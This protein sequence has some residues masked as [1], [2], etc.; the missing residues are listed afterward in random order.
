MKN[1]KVFISYS[2]KDEAWKDR[3]ETHLRVLEMQELLNIWVDERIEGGDVWRDEIDESMNTSSVAILLVSANFLTSSFILKTEVPRLLLQ[4]K[5]RG[6][7]I[8]PVIIKPCAWSRVDWLARLQVRPRGGRPLSEGNE[9]Q[10]DV[11]LST[12]SLE[13][14]DIISSI[15]AETS[16]RPNGPSGNIS[17]VGPIAAEAGEPTV[18]KAVVSQSAPRPITER[19]QI[20]AL[21]YALTWEAPVSEQDDLDSLHAVLPASHSVCQSVISGY[22]AYTTVDELDTARIYF[23]YPRANGDDCEQAVRCALGLIKAIQKLNEGH[24]TEHGVKL[25]IRIGIHTG[26]AI[27]Q[28]RP[29]GTPERAI[30]II[31]SISRVAEQL[32]IVAQSDSIFITD[33]TFKMIKG[34]FEVEELGTQSIGRSDSA[35]H[36]YKVLRESTARSRLDVAAMVGLT[37][38]IA[39][40]QEVA[41]LLERWNQVVEGVGQ[42]VLISGEAG[43]GK[44]RIVRVLKE[45]VAKNPQAWLTECFCSPYQSNTPLFPI[46]DL[47]DR[48][49]FNSERLR[50]A[51]SYKKLV[52]FLTQ[53]GMSSPEMITI[54]S[55]LLAVPTEE[56]LSVS[57]LSP[58]QERKQILEALIAILLEVAAGQPVVLVVEDLQWADPTTLELLGMLVDQGTTAPILSVFT[59]RPNFEAPWGIRSHINHIRLTGLSPTNIKEMVSRIAGKKVLP[60]NIISHVV[61]SSDGIPLFVEEL[62]KTVIEADFL[63]DAG[64]HYELRQPVDS[65]IIPSTLRESLTA[66]L[67]RLGEEKLVAQIA[68]TIGREFTFQL[69]LKVVASKD[70][71]ALEKD[72]STLVRGD[73]LYQRGVPP[74]SAYTFK[75]AL[76]QEAAYESLL[77][78][79]RQAYHCRIAGALE[80]IFPQITEGQ[81]ELLARHY[82]IGGQNEQAVEYLGRAADRALQRSAYIEA[83]NHITSGL[84]LV[85]G[86]GKTPDHVRKELKFQI[87]LGIALTATRGYPNS[88]VEQA[89]LRAKALSNEV[90]EGAESYDVSLGLWKIYASRGEILKAHQMAEDLL[91]LANKLKEPEMILTANLAVGI[92]LLTMGKLNNAEEHFKQ[93]LDKYEPE[94]YRAVAVKFGQDPGLTAMAWS[95]LGLWLR[96]YPSRARLLTQQAIDLAHK[97]GHPYSLAYVLWTTAEIDLIDRD[98]SAAQSKAEELHELCNEHHFELY[99]SYESILRGWLAVRKEQNITGVHEMSR[100]LAAYERIGG[101]LQRPFLLGLIADAYRTTGKAAE[102]LEMIDKALQIAD[103]THEQW[104]KAELL[105]LKAELFTQCPGRFLL[106]AKELH[107]RAV[108]VAESQGACSLALRATISLVRLWQADE[109]ISQ[110]RDRLRNAYKAMGQNQSS[111]DL[112]EAEHLLELLDRPLS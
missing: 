9:H 54:F 45:H 74:R 95:A 8:F 91:A 18:R 59:F 44:S 99:K 97:Q 89:Y 90:G 29:L 32:C 16:L 51:N 105:R 11:D 37:P 53:Y 108:E 102:G 112:R 55:S 83:I 107:H 4:H 57:N 60:D 77:K 38:F 84:K 20:T 13:I 80:T 98:V 7:R 41:S 23:G 48:A 42:T 79:E 27:V 65:L 106:G 81:P 66:R 78:T 12:I 5:D 25:S 33:A 47:F 26:L 76:I 46:I 68:A 40:T 96:G 17:N 70:E 104:Y 64:D 21:N 43:I 87:S 69:L 88:E 71:E 110:G 24:G 22:E 10:I 1:T 62:T 36:L 49:I 28:D 101:K 30:P 19:R 103:A 6:M 94:R 3:L 75:H 67:D 111:V 56:R 63:R 93:A 82:L 100:G 31:G 39:R 34:Y 50:N 52:G 72:L 35:L 86:H 73:L 92:F 2:H 109:K 58:S 85:G 14:V 15:G 61:S